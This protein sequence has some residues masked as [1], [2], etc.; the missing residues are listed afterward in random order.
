MVMWYDTNVLEA[1]ATSIFRMKC[2]LEKATW[3]SE[4]L[5]SY[6]ITAWCHN[7]DDNNMNFHHHENFKSCIRL[8][9]FTSLNGNVQNT[10][11]NK[12]PHNTSSTTLL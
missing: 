11:L 10:P 12:A 5:V 2:F 1:H 9:K 4:T 3:L 7:P 8:I 6:H